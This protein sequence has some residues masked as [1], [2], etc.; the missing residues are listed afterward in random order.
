MNNSVYRM[1][2][3]LCQKMGYFDAYSNLI[4]CLDEKADPVQKN[5]LI[6]GK[7]EDI[8][9]RNSIVFQRLTLKH[10]SKEKELSQGSDSQN[11]VLPPFVLPV[12]FSWRY[13]NLLK[14]M[15]S[16]ELRMKYHKSVLGWVWAMMEK[17]W[18]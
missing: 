15:V 6:A 16:R 12:E 5:K 13:R 3:E 4:E 9:S 11:G 2:I 14:G 1:L 7:K 8:E 10:L 18:L 17:D